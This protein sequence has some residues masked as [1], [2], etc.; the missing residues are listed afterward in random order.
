VQNDMRIVS[1]N[2][3]KTLVWKREHDVVLWRHNQRTSSNNDYHTPL[4]NIR[5]WWGHTLRQFPRASP[6]VCTL[7]HPNLPHEIYID[8]RD[9]T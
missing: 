5:I 6:D 2:F 1:A 4:L 9:Q 7:L 3:A 8:V